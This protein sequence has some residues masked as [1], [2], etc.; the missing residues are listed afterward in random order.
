MSQLWKLVLLCGLLTGTSASLLEA[1]GNGLS[2]DVEKLKPVISQGLKAV[3]DILEV[4][5]QKL[6]LEL[7]L[8]QESNAWQL[9]KQKI[10]EAGKLVGNVLSPLLPSFK[11][12]WGIKVNGFQILDIK[13]EP[14]EDGSIFNFRFPI[15]ASISVNLP[16]VHRDVDLKVSVDLMISARIQTDPQTNQPTV[17]LGECTSDLA[18]VSLSLSGGAGAKCDLKEAVN[19]VLV[20]KTSHG[21]LGQA[22]GQTNFELINKVLKPVVKTLKPAVS[23]KLQSQVCPLIRIVIQTLD[24]VFIQ[25]IVSRAGCVGKDWTEGLGQLGSQQVSSEWLL[26]EGSRCC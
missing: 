2:N 23:L 25:N 13:I 3:D 21:A 12:A 10:L 16:L 26:P 19:E 14:T 6:K 20:V 1:L 15:T 18:S 9:V 8:L 11:D 17:I 24:P 5:L 7:K 22:A 4:P